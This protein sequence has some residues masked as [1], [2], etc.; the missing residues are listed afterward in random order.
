MYYIGLKFISQIISLKYVNMVQY[1]TRFNWYIKWFSIYLKIYKHDVPYMIVTFKSNGS[2]LFSYLTKKLFKYYYVAYEIYMRF[3]WYGVYIFPG[4]RSKDTIELFKE[5]EEST[6]A[7]IRRWR[8][9]NSA[10]QSCLL[11]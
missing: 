11:D 4:D 8:N 1:S 5:C 2:K 6:K 7:E 9:H 10:G 3:W